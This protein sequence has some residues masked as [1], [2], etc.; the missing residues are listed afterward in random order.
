[1]RRP[2]AGMLSFSCSRMVFTFWAALEVRLIMVPWLLRAAL[3]SPR[4]LFDLKPYGLFWEGSHNE[5]FRGAHLPTPLLLSTDPAELLARLVASGLRGRGG[6]WYPA[7]RKWRAV[8]AEG[9]E[10]FLVAN[11]A[12]GEPGSVKDRHLLRTRA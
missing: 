9:G 4:P 12:E 5:R 11:G 2:P 8:R 10:P 6:G 7:A 3:P 1:M